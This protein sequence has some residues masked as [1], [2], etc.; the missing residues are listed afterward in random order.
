[1][2]K[3]SNPQTYNAL[4][5]SLVFCLTDTPQ[6]EYDPDYDDF[7]SHDINER[8]CLIILHVLVL[9]F[10]IESAITAGFVTRWLVK[11]PWGD[12]QERQAHLVDLVKRRNTL[13]DIICQVINNRTGMVQLREAGLVG[14][15][16][17]GFDDTI[18]VRMVNGEST[19]GEM[20]QPD[21]SF[22][23]G[24]QGGTRLREQSVE[25]TIL[26][27]RH[28]EAMVLNDGVQ[29]IGRDDIFEREDEE[30]RSASDDRQRE[31]RSLL[32]RLRS[33]NS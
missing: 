10:G 15:G 18:D 30:S 17:D 13:S 27:R 11:L 2:S 23:E 3:L 9:N 22:L 26:R 6:A 7:D 21:M 12:T 14:R 24:P 28:R 8:L 29:P 20:D 31:L 32:A 19:A 5:T 33:N 16:L 4:V 25:E 1:M